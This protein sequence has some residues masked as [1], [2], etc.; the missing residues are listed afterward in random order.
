MIFFKVLKHNYFWYEVNYNKLILGR[1]INLFLSIRMNDF[2]KQRLALKKGG[3]A[4]SVS[5]KL[6]KN[7]FNLKKNI[8]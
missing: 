6:K 7:V 3:S 4:I 8:I 5:E 1:Y 2:K